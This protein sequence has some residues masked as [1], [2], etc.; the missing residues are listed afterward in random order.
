MAGEG[1]GGASR[2]HWEAGLAGVAVL[3]GWW[4]S[5]VARRGLAQAQLASPQEQAWQATLQPALVGR[6]KS[7]PDKIRYQR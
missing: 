2:G 4:D 3:I 6:Y 1:L 5:R 7:I